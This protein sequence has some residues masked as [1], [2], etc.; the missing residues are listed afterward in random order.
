MTCAGVVRMRSVERVRVVIRVCHDPI[1]RGVDLVRDDLAL[2][3]GV[4]LGSAFGPYLARL[5]GARI[6]VW[7][8][9]LMLV[10][11]LFA[12]LEQQPHAR[13]TPRGRRHLQR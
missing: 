1:G 10:F 12:M 3:P 8:F 9:V 7:I 13:N 5:I 11:Q 6:I 4:F 2:A